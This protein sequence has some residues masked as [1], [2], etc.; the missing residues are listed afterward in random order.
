VST[1]DRIT[2]RSGQGWSSPRR[3]KGKS[4]TILYVSELGCREHGHDPVARE[5]VHRAAVPLHY[6]RSAVGEVGHEISRSR[7]APTAAAMSIE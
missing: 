3:G 4:P 5:L 7:S 2:A 1:A 6:C